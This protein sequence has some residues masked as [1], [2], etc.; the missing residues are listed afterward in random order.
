MNWTSEQLDQTLRTLVERSI[1]DKDF[2]ALAVTDAN[3]AIKAVTDTPVPA[4]FRIRFV[5]NAGY[6]MTVVLPDPPATA[7]QQPLDDAELAGVAGGTLGGFT[8]GNCGISTIACGGTFGNLT[9]CNPGF[10]KKPGSPA[11]CPK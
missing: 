7:Q 8:L 2:R 3:A 4:G 1:S 5:D 10:T 6:D 9:A 11:F